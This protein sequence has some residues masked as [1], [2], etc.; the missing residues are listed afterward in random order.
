[1]ALNPR[2]FFRQLF[3]LTVYK[4]WIVL[5]NHWFINLLRCF[6]VPV[7]FAVF[8][9]YMPNFLIRASDLGFGSPATIYSLQ[10]VFDSGKLVWTD[11]TDGTGSPSANQI[12][13]LVA[14]PLSSAR[15][16]SV[17]KVDNLDALELA[18]PSNYNGRTS[19]YAG[20]IFNGLPRSNDSA[21]PIFYIIR[22]DMGE[23]YV[24]VKR[25]TGDYEKNLLPIQWAID[26]AI[27]ELKTGVK[28][29]TPLEQPYTMETNEEQAAQTRQ[30]FLTF[31]DAVLVIAFWLF[32]AGLVY[33][34]AGSIA[35]ERA[36]ELSMHLQAMGC[37][38]SARA[39]SW[40]VSISLPYVPA[41]IIAA[42]FWHAKIFTTNN[43]GTVILINIV[44]GFSISGWSIF[45]ATFFGNSPQL[46]A[47][48]T[49]GIGFVSAILAMVFGHSPFAAWIFTLF[50]PPSFL[51]FAL[52]ALAQKAVYQ[53]E[54]EDAAQD[55][56]TNFSW[57]AP[58][59]P[60][61][62][63]GD[64]M[65]FAIHLL[66]DPK[67]APSLNRKPG[68]FARLFGRGGHGGTGTQAADGSQY[69]IQIQNLSK[70]W[71]K[72]RKKEVVAI[73]DLSLS[74]P[75]NG[76]Y[77]VLAKSALPGSNGSG[78]STL[79][80]I[81][82]NIISP[83][84]GSITFGGTDSR[85]ARGSVGIVPQKNV[86]FP[87]LTCYQTVRLWSAI[88]SPL[89]SSESKATLE[90]LLVDCDLS[91]KMHARSGEMSGGQK[92][93]LQLAIGLVGG[94]NI[95][96]VDE[97]TSGVD[98]LS[99][100][101]IWRALIAVRDSRTIIFTTHFLDEADLLGDEI[102]ILAAP[103][104]LLAHGPPVA[105]KSALG[106]GYVLQTT[107]DQDHSSESARSEHRHA[108]LNR[109]KT[110]VPSAAVHTSNDKSVSFEL[111]TAD[112]KTVSSLLA[113]VEKER[114]NLGIRSYDTHGTSLEE[115]FLS[116][117]EKESSENEKTQLASE[118]EK[119]TPGIDASPVGYGDTDTTKASPLSDGR[120]TSVFSQALVVC[121]KR[122][123]IAR[124]SFLPPILALACL[125]C[126]SI[127]PLRYMVKRHET[128]AI[129]A[130][131]D[132]DWATNLYLPTAGEYTVGGGNFADQTTFIS[133]FDLTSY[134]GNITDFHVGSIPSGVTFSDFIAS[135]YKNLS[136]GGLSLDPSSRQALITYQSQDGALSGPALLNLASNIML[137][138]IE[139]SKGP[140]IVAQYSNFPANF[141]TGTADALKWIGF[142]GLGVAVFPAFAALY[143]ARERVSTV[144]A[145]Q[146]GNGL[147]P[148]AHH[149]G[150]LLAE[151]PVILI[152]STVAIAVFGSGNNPQFK[153][154]GLLWFLFVLYG[155]AA[156]L[157]S[158]IAAL[159]LSSPLM[160][161]AI[162]AVY[163]V[164]VG[165]ILY[166]A[167]YL[168]TLTYAPP[169]S[170]SQDTL[171][172][173]FAMGLL[174]P[175][176]S[177][178]RSVLVSLN[179]FSLRCDGFGNDTTASMAGM[180]FYG[181]PILYLVLYI[182]IF[183]SLLV[184][185]DSG[186]PLPSRLSSRRAKGATDDPAAASRQAAD[187]AEEKRRVLAPSNS[188][189]LRVLG[190]SKQFARSDVKA[191]DNVTFGV[192]GETVGLLGPNGAGKTT[193][194]N[195]I[196]GGIKPDTGDVQVNGLSIRED[197]NGARV[198][199]GLC[200]QFTAIDSQLTVREHLEVYGRLKGLRGRELDQNVATLLRMA[201]LAHYRDRLASKL[202]GGNQRKMALAIALMGN[203]SVILIDEYSTGI[204]P[205]TKRHMWATL[206]QLSVGKAVL[207]T[208]H[209]MEEAAYL[210]NRVAIIS[211]R[212]LAIGTVEDLVSRHPMYEVHVS[213]QTPE[214]R[215]RAQAVLSNLFPDCRPADDVATRWEVPV[216]EGRT[217]SALFGAL[218]GQNLPE[219]A[220]ERLSLESVFLKTIR[221]NNAAMER[222][223]GPRRKKWL[224]V[225]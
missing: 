16:Q 204:D 85:P 163:N 198:G 118:P 73:R 209:S 224:G 173:H 154:L 195:M 150:H 115:V 67:P 219:Y 170:S 88:K 1:M 112:P 43:I 152:G 62:S 131:S 46:S 59:G 52:R 25:H 27:I 169:A 87:E 142:F 92:R 56:S 35:R 221:N 71:N 153:E 156:T 191:V 121:L 138:Q 72:G 202:S 76:V 107:L 4:N 104:K 128:C 12:M 146:L 78:K 94:S 93:K 24:N 149:L 136:I 90:Q 34:M 164:V 122:F 60:E 116:L 212:L 129:S 178:F 14:Q 99:R 65:V 49:T 177:L 37:L 50:L 114:Q 205:A 147:T 179:V 86:L 69:A 7:A 218:S 39:L 167:A 2:L 134:L 36:S 55:G 123:M 180:K 174:G 84:S 77:V 31:I 217:L 110:V 200:P 222:E 70:V 210:S 139:N 61:F 63:L 124:R 8:L 23:G 113:L 19:C 145:M 51:V 54:L 130:N 186:Y 213:C 162:V 190:I 203:P 64:T 207:I 102:A 160:A 165:Y 176:P 133:P 32:F 158:F 9:G 21:S 10:D 157:F 101:A 109:V 211:G 58:D 96:L 26:S 155:I 5:G 81:I 20:I 100:R 171:I 40:F 187:V 141:P 144:K 44:A 41:W 68:F 182:A 105:L 57:D 108:I 17:I 151:M 97:A 189:P 161:F 3:A 47:I 42:A 28:P 197:A 117:M 95:V 135:N 66:Y 106:R 83:T 159:F 111:G 48:C 194:F 199:L 206:K 98:P 33:Q 225:F 22:G 214:A 18:C 89:G 185:I 11:I 192:G 188:D 29:P 13:D 79:H 15:R 45:V 137:N 183:F 193:T 103:G 126:A 140:K 80:G 132:P 166:L 181:G 148:A 201:E 30:D 172:V 6:L 196:R 175:L 53:K 82:G 223:D 215:Q 184:W 91:R 220:V 125:L 38:R 119:L 216:S 74:I 208:T 168:L 120:K 143:V 127:I 75:R